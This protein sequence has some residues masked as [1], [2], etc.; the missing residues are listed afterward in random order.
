MVPI[1]EDDLQV[2]FIIEFVGWQDPELVSGL[3]ERS[4]LR[5]LRLRLCGDRDRFCSFEE[6]SAGIGPPR[7]KYFPRG[8]Y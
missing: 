1:I 5:P 8:S 3:E 6:P 4:Q 7:W 2:V